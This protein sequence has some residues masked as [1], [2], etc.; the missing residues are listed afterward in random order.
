MWL[1]K[2]FI[3]RGV[4]KTTKYFWNV[5]QVIAFRDLKSAVTDKVA[6][7][8]YSVDAH[9]EVIADVSE[10]GLGAVLIQKDKH[11]ESRVIAYAHKSLSPREQKYHILETEAMALVR[12][13][14]AF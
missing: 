6:L 5:E 1:L 3:F 13:G 14:G 12:G 10:V 7:G 4:I 9:T 11:N 8:F 2:H